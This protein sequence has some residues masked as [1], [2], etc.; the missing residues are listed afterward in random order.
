MTKINNEQPQQ[1]IL[2]LSQLS[3]Q[4]NQQKNKPGANIL[5]FPVVVN[6]DGTIVGSRDLQNINS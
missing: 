6:P 3:Q 4:L 2:S 5:T 1:I